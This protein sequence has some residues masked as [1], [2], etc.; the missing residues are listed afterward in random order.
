[1]CIRFSDNFEDCGPIEVVG[2]VGDTC[3]VSCGY[4]CSLSVCVLA[5]LLGVTVVIQVIVSL[6]SLGFLG[7]D[8]LSISDC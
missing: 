8:F 3:G 2:S 7:E 5:G 1:M 4:S 6:S